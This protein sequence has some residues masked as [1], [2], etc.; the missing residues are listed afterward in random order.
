MI[1]PIMKR[2]IKSC[3]SFSSEDIATIQDNIWTAQNSDVYSSCSKLDNTEEDIGNKRRPLHLT[4]LLTDLTG[5]AW[6]IQVVL[7]SAASRK[8]GCITHCITVMMELIPRYKV[9]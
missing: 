2:F 3:A 8:K 9:L 1:P 7:I 4:T 5:K 6:F